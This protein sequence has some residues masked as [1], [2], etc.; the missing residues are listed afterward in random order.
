MPIS[1]EG[2]LFLPVPTSVDDNLVLPGT[3]G[4]QLPEQVEV[5][6]SAGVDSVWKMVELDLQPVSQLV[7]KLLLPTT[8][9]GVS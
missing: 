4:L 3:S 5:I 8:K 7:G 6:N 2:Q 1:V 9:A